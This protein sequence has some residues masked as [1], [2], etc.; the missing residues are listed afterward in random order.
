METK[1]K[2]SLK[3]LSYSELVN[4]VLECGYPKFRADQIYTW[5]YQ[6]NAQTF[7]KMTNLPK[8]L[9]EYLETSYSL[10]SLSILNIQ[11]SKDGTRKYLMQ[12]EDGL[13]V[14]TVG[15]PSH[16]KQRLTVCFSTQVGC[17]MQ[18]DFCATGKEGFSRN[19]LPGEICDQILLV[20]NDFGSRVTNVVGMGQGEPFL[21]FKNVQKA[22]TILNDPKG[23]AIGARHITISTCGIIP[24]IESFSKISEQYTLA[25]SLHSAIQETRDKL[26]PKVT[27]YPL[28]S[29]K[30]ALLN[31]IKATDRRVTLEYAMINGVNDTEEHLNALIDFCRNLL[32][33]INLIQLNEISDAIYKPSDNATLN[34]WITTLNECH[35]ETTLRRSKGSDISAA[36]GQLKNSL[37]K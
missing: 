3:S 36:C 24:Q 32:C 4:L 26:M 17:A 31:Y 22:L 20:Q 35:I 10:S 34:H 13:L 2:I 1:T 18:C 8:Q 19:L 25:I 23:L 28:S 27:C 30:M 12:L 15:I 37:A 21:N 33:H 29:L 5:M 14:E 11:K 7:E 6:H 9:R 16:N